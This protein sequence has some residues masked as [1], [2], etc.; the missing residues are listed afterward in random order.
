[1]L[2]YPIH[3]MSISYVNIMCKICIRINKVQYFLA[4][5]SR[6]A[7]PSFGLSKARGSRSAVPSYLT[8]AFYICNIAYK[9]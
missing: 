2:C 1:V 4:Y 9:K 6:P 8:Y 5:V 7:I 3:G